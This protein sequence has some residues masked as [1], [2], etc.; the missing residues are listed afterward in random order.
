MRS[1]TEFIEQSQDKREVKRAI[2]VKMLLSGHK[3]GDVVTCGY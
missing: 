2:A 1:L 3:L